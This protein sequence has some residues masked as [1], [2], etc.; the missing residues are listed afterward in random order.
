MANS[1]AILS[2]TLLGYFPAP[3][4]SGGVADR[5]HSDLKGSTKFAMG[6]IT[7]LAI[8]ATLFLLIAAMFKLSQ[9]AKG[10]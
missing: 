10:L 7:Y 9:D 8:L 6:S 5:D 3:F 4:I 2:F 1:L